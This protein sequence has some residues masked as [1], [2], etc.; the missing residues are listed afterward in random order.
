MWHGDPQTLQAP[1]H[2]TDS[3]LSPT[4]RLLSSTVGTQLLVWPPSPSMLSVQR[5]GLL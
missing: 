1:K 3:P 5:P 4:S 2:M